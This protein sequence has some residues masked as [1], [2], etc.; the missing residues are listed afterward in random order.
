MTQT[1]SGEQIY[2]VI[3]V[4]DKTQNITGNLS[5][6]IDKYNNKRLISV[7]ALLI[8]KMVLKIFIRH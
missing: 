4:P 8:F 2:V 3:N 5:T 6:K 7:S 1:S